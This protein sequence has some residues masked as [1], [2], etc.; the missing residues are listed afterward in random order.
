MGIAIRLTNLS[1]MGNN[2]ATA[3]RYTTTLVS[4]GKERPL[5]PKYILEGE[6]LHRTSSQKL[7]D[8]PHTD[9]SKCSNPTIHWS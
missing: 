8:K 7:I 3:A 1:V 2:L 4:S 6:Y 9:L 5:R